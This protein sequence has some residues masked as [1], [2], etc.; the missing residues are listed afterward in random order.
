MERKMMKL[1]KNMKKKIKIKGNEGGRRDR[2][3]ILHL[4]PYR[5]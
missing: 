5:I 4:H 2:G 3:F 1:N